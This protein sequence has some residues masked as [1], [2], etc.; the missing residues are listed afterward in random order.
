MMTWMPDLVTTIL[1]L[2]ALA[3]IVSAIIWNLDR[4]R[5]DGADPLVSPAWTI[6]ARPSRRWFRGKSSNPDLPRP[7]DRTDTG[8]ADTTPDS[9]CA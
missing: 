6:L 2:A 5:N 7:G 3:T 4:F 9:N 8:S 1:I